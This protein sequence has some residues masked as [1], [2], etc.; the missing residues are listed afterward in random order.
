ML[1]RS[2]HIYVHNDKAENNMENVI[3]DKEKKN[4]YIV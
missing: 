3:E 2:I 1:H 4:K